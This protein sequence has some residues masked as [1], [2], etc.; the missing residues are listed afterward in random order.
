[1]RDLN[2][3]VAPTGNAFMRDIASWLV[4]AGQQLGCRSTLRIDG[5][6]PDDAS[7][8][9]LVVAPHEFYLLSEF[10]D[11][12]IH[13]ATQVSIPVC[14]EQPG[15]PWFEISAITTRSSPIALD[16][17]AHG[18]DALTARGVDARHLRLGAV[19][20]M[21][22]S[23]GDTVRRDIDLV[24]LAGQTDRRSARLAQ[25]APVL[26]NRNADL[27]LF[28]FTRP[29][30]DGV[31]GL[32]FG[33][34]K[35]RLLARSR[36]LLNIHRDDTRPGYFEWARMVEAMANGCCVITEP[37]TGFDP[38]IEGEHFVAGDDLERVVAELLDDPQRCEQIGRAART[39]V[40]DQF[41]LTSSLRPLLDE[42][43]RRQIVPP[44]S[45]RRVPKY[46]R[47]MIVAQQHPLLPAFRP[48]Q[49][50][51]VRT[52]R[53]LMA[54]TRLQREIERTRCLLRHGTDDFIER[55]ESAAYAT[56]SPEVSVIVTLFNYAH[57]VVETLDSILASVGVDVEI[58]VVDDHSTDEGR[59]TVRRFIA[60]HPDASVLLLGC[61]VNRGLPAARNLGF[62]HAR[63][64]KVMVMDADNLVYPSAMR[65]IADALDRD[66]TAAFAYSTL[67]EFGTKPGLRSAM[68][69]HVP[70]L[71]ERNYI[72][73]QAMIRRDAWERH[74]GYRIDD[75]LIFGWEDW[76]LWLRFA[77]AGEHG[78]HV[79]QMLGCY[80][81]Q[82]QSM[83]S[84]TNLAADHMIAHVR[85]KYPTLPW[86]FTADHTSVAPA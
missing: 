12:T 68:A 13:R 85:Q 59:D 15:T 20:S 53:A 61:D 82:E 81:T 70:W 43:D 28:S 79:A 65:K 39:A 34:D 75:E 19:P 22:A 48:A 21:D 23:S 58:V 31:P 54:E 67:E 77:A 69:W 51:R 46:R 56:A 50:I 84:T 36:I 4:E 37:V 9:N 18:V 25:V 42:L 83:L 32:V 45:A 33:Q 66:P 14:T 62:E 29:V 71:C 55:F 80:R 1:V 40:L 8:V 26:W 7:A 52:Y 86:P 16:I 76:E 44:T 38:L 24:F 11:A 2:V 10:D 49:E 78:L 41:P 63:A 6:A 64:D 3:F 35:Y 47:Q 73:A 5:T 30:A 72:D 74:G 17:N 27:R 57:V 60:D